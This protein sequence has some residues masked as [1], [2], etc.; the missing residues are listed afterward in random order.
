MFLFHDLNPAEN[1]RFSI[2]MIINLSTCYNKLE[3]TKI[4]I[5]LCQ[6][7]K[8]LYSLRIPD[9]SKN[10]FRAV[11]KDS[12]IHKL[13]RHLSRDSDVTLIADKSR[14]EDGI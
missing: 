3:T 2:V 14:M 1:S 13:T 7:V 12:T 5:N 11:L 4:A 10:N 9:A 8:K 6:E